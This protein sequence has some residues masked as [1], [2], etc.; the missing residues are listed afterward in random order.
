MKVILQRDEMDCGACSLASIVKH[1][2]GNVPME[3]VRSD[4]FTSKHGTTAL[5]I[6]LASKRYG[7]EAVGMKLDDIN[8]IDKFPAI[9]HLNLKNGLNHFVVVYKIKNN[10]IILMDPA[11]GKVVKDKKEFAEEWS[12]VVIMFYPSYKIINVKSEWTIFKILKEIFLKEKKIVCLI[13]LLSLLLTFLAVVLNY[14]FEVM[15]SILNYNSFKKIIFLFASFVLFKLILMYIRDFLINFLNK[16]IDYYL[17]LKFLSHLYNLPLD[18]I[19]S[20]NT[21]DI[22]TRINEIRKI[23]ELACNLFVLFSLC[24]FMIILIWPLLFKINNYLFLILFINSLL[25][26]VIGFILGRKIY[27]KAYKNITLEADFNNVLL[28]DLNMITSIVNLN[29]HTN[30]LKRLK[31]YLA[32]Y[33]NGLY[34]FSRFISLDKILK[35]VLTEI[36]LFLIN[37]LGMYLILN[38]KLSLVS[39]ITF[40][41]LMN[42]YLDTFC[43]LVDDIP[44]YMYLKACVLKL[45]EFLGIRENSV[46]CSKSM[47]FKN[48]SIKNLSFS[49]NS[50][51]SLLK[52]INI[53][54]KQGLTLIRGSSGSGKSTLCKI[55][56]KRITNYNGEIYIDE[57][58]LQELSLLDINEN[59]IYVGQNENLFAGTIRENILL[60][61]NVDDLDFMNISKMCHVNDFVNNKKLSYDSYMNEK[62]NLSGG[63]RQRI[64]LAR[65]L[66]SDFKVLILDEALSEVDYEREIDILN[67]LRKYFRNTIILYISHKKYDYKFDEIVDFNPGTKKELMEDLCSY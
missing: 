8:F 36:N 25:Y 12:Q 59:I 37:S 64:I 57:E 52:D 30:R 13:I 4:T 22:M 19:L 44:Q 38:N 46:R 56:L 14:F 51:N 47:L 7:F 1:Y 41:F 23:K 3:M 62:I 66:L 32:S 40:N 31:K 55:L 33:L 16:N 18:I 17:H 10:K 49:Y 60:D 35:N 2:G 27:F 58:N 63:E 42:L 6:I 34:F 26:L 29:I 21:G 43:T 20:R 48:I 5:N 54:F 15:L 11:V 45:N 67:N 53:I 65:S 9:A 39:L 24:I 61:R 28:E 50:Q